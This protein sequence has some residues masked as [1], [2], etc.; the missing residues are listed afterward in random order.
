[1]ASIEQ[2]QRLDAAAS[3]RKIRELIE[4]LYTLPAA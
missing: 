1:V 3:R 4:E 2:N